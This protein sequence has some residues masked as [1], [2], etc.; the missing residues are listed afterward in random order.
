MPKLSKEKMNQKKDYILD[1]AFELFAEKGYDSTSIRD[2]MDRANVSKGGIYVHFNSK[3]DILLAIMQRVDLDRKNIHLNL[4]KDMPADEMLKSYLIKRLNNFKEEKN[5]KWIRINMMF[6]TSQEKTPK[7]KELNESR[8]NFYR[9]DLEYILIKGVEDGIFYLNC[10]MD[11]V[12]YNIMSLIDGIAVMSGIL[13]KVITDEQINDI[14][15]MQ[16]KNLYIT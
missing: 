1:V 14:V 4:D 10:N 5:Q 13:G 3:L 15:N 7:I 9:E 8:Y 6:W 16:I 11:S 2:I 12:V